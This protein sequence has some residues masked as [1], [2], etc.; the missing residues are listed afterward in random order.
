ML[1]NATVSIVI[2]TVA[3]ICIIRILYQGGCK[4]PNN[5]C[6]TWIVAKKQSYKSEQV[7][8][9]D[10]IGIIFE[11]LFIRTIVLIAAAVALRLFMDDNTILTWSGYLKEWEKWDAVHYIRLAK[12]GYTAY[13]ENGEPILLAFF[14]LYSIIVSC[15]K[16]IIPN[17]LLSGLLVS[18]LCYIAGC[19]FFYALVVSEYGK[20]IGKRAVFYISIFPF[21]FYF[22][23]IMTESL[24]FLTVSATLYYI[25]KHNW[26][27]VALTGILASLSRMQGILII[28]P[29][30]IEIIVTYKVFDL[31]RKKQWNELWEKVIKNTFWV[32]LI[33]VGPVIYLLCNYL[34]TGNAF[35]FLIY[36]ET[37]W[38]HGPQYIG[39]AIN[40]IIRYI[41]SSK[42]VGATMVAIWIPQL[43]L[44]IL[45]LLIMCYAVRRHADKY[46]L[47]FL[48]YTIMN[49][50]LSFVISGARYMSTAVPM[51]FILAEFVERHKWIDKW[52]TMISILLL[53]IYLT[54]YLFY[55]QIM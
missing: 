32:G 55:K 48:F 22:G 27:V 8:K 52:I 54:G 23:G 3:I 45:A 26:S 51:F 2:W 33:C 47:Y 20:E 31:I 46:V 39:N 10:I 25:K 29:A 6:V 44:F 36:Q 4:V 34:V 42:L 53:G 17:Y 12:G 50:S 28:I 15:M 43:I 1:I 11:A 19:C 37:I 30:T 18:I 24:F 41:T 49:Y 35:Q 5:A 21:S 14:P 16:L 40:T 7:N 9:R 38:N 13:Y